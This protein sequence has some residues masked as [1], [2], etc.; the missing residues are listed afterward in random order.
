M[1]LF[2]MMEVPFHLRHQC[3]GG[4]FWPSLIRPR[5]TSS[6][7]F[8][9]GDLLFRM[10]A[11]YAPNAPRELDNSIVYSLSLDKGFTQEDVKV[12]VENGMLKVTAKHE[13]KDEKGENVVSTM[14][15]SQMMS[16]PEECDTTEEI[17]TTLN[18]NGTLEITVGKKKEAIE[19]K[20]QESKP[21]QLATFPVEGYA[22]QE[23]QVLLSSTGNLEVIG[24]HEEKTEDGTV[25]A[26]RQFH[27]VL[28]LPEGIKPEDIKSSLSKDSRLLTIFA[29]NAIAEEPK[30]IHIQMEDA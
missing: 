15:M 21:T 5:Y 3:H 1:D 7:L 14:Q 19:H 18:E 9:I 22:P 30:N 20:E 17:K 23:L 12:Q 28:P 26:A 13:E 24:K 16:L 8:P 29:A 4:N 10:P 2:S 25:V 27:T 11:N 6:P